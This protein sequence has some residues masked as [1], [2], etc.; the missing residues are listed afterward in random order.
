MKVLADENCELELVDRLRT[1]GYDV[2][3]IAELAPSIDDESIFAIA[4]SDGRVLLTSDQDFGLIAE[5]AR[6]RPPAV[7]LM[8]LER[9]SPPR[10]VQIVLD[11]L[12]SLSGASTGVFIVIEPHQVRSRQYE[13]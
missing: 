1:R 7:A 8:R 4:Q 12:D 2:V 6:V 3:T 9:V 13:P 10:R 5:H 11:A